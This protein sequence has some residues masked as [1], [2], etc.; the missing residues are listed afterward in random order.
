LVF[1]LLVF[2]LEGCVLKYGGGS[3]NNIW[4]VPTNSTALEKSTGLGWGIKWG[5]GLGIFFYISS[6]RLR[7]EVS[8]FGIEG[9]GIWVEGS[10]LRV[11]G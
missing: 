10:G 2:V 5:W 11:G 9:L 8:G 4:A 1:G 3:P 7:I 6:L